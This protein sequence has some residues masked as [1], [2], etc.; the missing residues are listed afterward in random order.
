MA[1]ESF[2]EE[3]ILRLEDLIK[4]L[5]RKTDHEIEKLHREVDRETE[6]LHR[7][8]EKPHPIMDP[9]TDPPGSEIHRRSKMKED[10]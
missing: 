6:K 3:K 8:V 7:E 10:Y 5:H 2:E 4:N 1:E 9:E